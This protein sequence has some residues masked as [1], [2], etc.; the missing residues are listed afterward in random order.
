MRAWD[1]GFIPMIIQGEQI[2]LAAM[3]DRAKEEGLLLCSLPLC[4]CGTW[5]SPGVVLLT[6]LE[7]ERCVR[8]EGSS[9]MYLLGET[10][11]FCITGQ[12]PRKR[13][14]QLGCIPWPEV[15]SGQNKSHKAISGNLRA[16]SPLQGALT[17]PRIP[18]HTF[19]GRLCC[20]SD[21]H[22][23]VFA[24]GGLHSGRWLLRAWKHKWGTREVS[25]SCIRGKN[26]SSLAAG[27]SGKLSTEDLFSFLHNTEILGGKREG[28]Q[29]HY[30][31]SLPQKQGVRRHP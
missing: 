16:A 1:W 23:T 25:L 20:I 2:A 31:P 30:T 19:S 13:C 9:P 24:T 10:H 14:S 3:T 26:A 5:T 8:T 21:L 12:R 28:R 18:K 27:P 17:L 15:R 29:S 6:V 7:F 22:S 4:T 11:P